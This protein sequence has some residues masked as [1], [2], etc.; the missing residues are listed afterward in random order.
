MTYHI[1]RAWLVYSLRYAH[2][3]V[4]PSVAVVIY[5]F[6]WIYVIQLKY[7]DD[8]HEIE[9]KSCRKIFQVLM[10]IWWPWA[11]GLTWITNTMCYVYTS[12]LWDMMRQTICFI[13]YVF[14]CDQAA[15][16]TG[17]SVRLSITPFSQCYCHHI[18][19]KFSSIITIEPN[20]CPCERSRSEMREQGHRGQNFFA[21]IRAFLDC[22]SSL[23]SQMTTK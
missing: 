6:L 11:E 20:W 15:L 18:I 3:C 14:S 1:D 21:P 4:V 8:K 13:L 16:W 10:K 7:T 2:D 23:N 12:I 9:Q 19:T 5:K 17:L 22:N